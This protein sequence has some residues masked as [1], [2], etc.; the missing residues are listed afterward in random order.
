MPVLQRE[1]AAKMD[2]ILLPMTIDSRTRAS[3]ADMGHPNQP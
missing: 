1:G 2:A 3:D